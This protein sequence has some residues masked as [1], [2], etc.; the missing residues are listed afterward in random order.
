MKPLKF[1]K[2]EDKE[3]LIISESYE[4]VNNNSQ[5]AENIINFKKRTK[6]CGSKF[7]LKVRSMSENVDY[8]LNRHIHSSIFIVIVISKLPDQNMSRYLFAIWHIFKLV[9]R[10]S[11]I[12][13]HTSFVFV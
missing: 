5:N 1:D 10:F 13:N 9:E 7:R 2:R 11:T 8:S 6:F 12:F 4:N 3:L